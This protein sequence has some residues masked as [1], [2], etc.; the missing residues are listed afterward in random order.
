[1]KKINFLNGKVIEFD[2]TKPPLTIELIPETSFYRNVRSKVDNNMW[3]KIRLKCYNNANHKC[4]ICNDTGKN[5]GFNHDVE[6][7]EIWDYDTITSTQLL[8][9]FIA[10]CPLCHKTKHY[11]L[12][13][14]NGDIDKVHK[15]LKKVNLMNETSID[16]MISR[17]YHEWE[18]RNLINWTVDISFI[19]NYIV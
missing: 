13:R 1:M 2:S 6:C 3:D 15:H 8:V 5:Q 4:E 7:H 9:G 14:L 11:G 12:A 17:C 16:I 18:L 19:N 10:L